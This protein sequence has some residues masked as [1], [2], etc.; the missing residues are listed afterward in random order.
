LKAGDIT[1]TDRQYVGFENDTKFHHYAI[2]VMK[3]Y[4]MEDD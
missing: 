2:D 3:E 4:E 1:I